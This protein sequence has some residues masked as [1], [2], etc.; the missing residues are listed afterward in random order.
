MNWL[1]ISVVIPLY[2]KRSDVEGCLR[3]VFSQTEPPYE[4]IV[5]DDGSTDGSADLV[6]S[7]YGDRITLIRQ[8][9]RGVSTARN[10]GIKYSS[11]EYIC[12]LD[13]DDQWLPKYLETMKQL[14][15]NYPEAVFY[16]INHCF[17]DENGNSFPSAIGLPSDFVGMVKDFAG[18]FSRGYGLASSSSVCVRKSVFANGICFP[19]HATRGE[20][21]ATWLEM[22][23]LGPMAFSAKPLAKIR[24]NASNRS[25]NRKSTLPHHFEWFFSMRSR[26]RSHR[27]GKSITRFIH[28]NAFVTTYGLCLV[29]DRA[30]ARKIMNL[31]ASN[32]NIHLLLML[33]ALWVPKKLLR[34]IMKWRRSNR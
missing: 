24:L 25:V 2:N 31:Y 26:I 27:Y 1:N 19:E 17:I 8:E 32:I 9:N 34:L 29:G 20:D 16:S 3:S 7:L 15:A 30:S 28:G 23:M 18:T 21:L 14:I 6:Q 5:V 22:G 33:P 10:T 11:E 12:L 13:A 4:I